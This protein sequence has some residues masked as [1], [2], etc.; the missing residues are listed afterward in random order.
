MSNEHRASTAVTPTRYFPPPEAEGGWRSLIPANE[1]PS[2]AEKQAV[3]ETTGL[4]WDWLQEA[5]EYCCGFGEPNGL[6]VIRHGWIAAEWM[7]YTDAQGIASC[8]KSLTSLAMAK[9]F[10]MSDQGQLPKRIGLEEY[11]YPFLP[12]TWIDADPRRKQ[13]R[14]RHMLT[15]TSGLVPYDGPYE[16]GYPEIVLNLPVEGP[17]GV[18]WAYSSVPVDLLKS[19]RGE[20]HGSNVTAVL[21][22]GDRP[23]HRRH[24][25]AVDRVRRPFPRVRRRAV[26]GTRARARRLSPAAAG[27][28]GRWERAYPIVSGERVA[29]ITQWAS[30]LEETRSEG[31]TGTFFTVPGA[32]LFHG[33]LWWTNRNHVPLGPAVPEDAFLMAGWGRQ[34]CMIIPSLDMIIVRLG[35]KGELNQEHEYF[36]EL[37]PRVMGAVT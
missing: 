6:L 19:C 7:D 26:H 28:L 9:L 31:P 5:W 25:G 20:R 10:D 12:P 22:R 34:V 23:G 1:M 32:R 33:Y 18:V 24:A 11:A 2:A 30:W 4:D 27:D 8:S 16:D 3:T 13:I 35:S 37:M 17:P 36:R 21:Q 14:L 15:M 29:L